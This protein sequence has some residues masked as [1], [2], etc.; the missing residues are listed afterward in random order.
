M[1]KCTIEVIKKIANRE[2]QEV[3]DVNGIQ[4]GVD[5]TC[6][7]VE[8]GQIYEY[9]NGGPMPEGFCIWAW[10]DM[11]RDIEGICAGANFHW[12]K[13][14]GTMISCCTDGLRP[15]VFRIQRVD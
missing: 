8:V 14:E 5:S 9:E 1:G 3:Y 7:A 11:H 13:G 12:I 15:V 4:E 10:A 2:L 6:P